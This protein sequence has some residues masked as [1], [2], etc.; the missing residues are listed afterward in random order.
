MNQVLS[1]DAEGGGGGIG[2]EFAKFDHPIALF[3]RGCLLFL[4]GKGNG[5][6]FAR[7][8]PTPNRN[9]Q[10]ALQNHVV[11]E[12]VGQA[13]VGVNEGAYREKGKQ[14]DEFCFHE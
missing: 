10:V 3:V 6:F 12:N 14:E 8:R 2:F 7:I 13:Y 11:A 4:P 5:D 1:L 9:L